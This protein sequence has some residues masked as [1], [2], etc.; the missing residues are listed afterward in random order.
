MFFKLERRNKKE[1]TPLRVSEVLDKHLDTLVRNIKIK[2]FVFMMMMFV[3]MGF[4]AYRFVIMTPEDLQKQ[5]GHIAHIEIS[6]EIS[7]SNRQGSGEPLAT[8][9][10]A[11]L[12][13]E[14]A[15]AILITANSGGGSPVQGEIINHAIKAVIQERDELG[16]DKPIVVV[17]EDVCASACY[18]AVSSAD[19]IYAHSSSLVGSIGVRMD[20]WQLADGLARLGVKR[21]TLTSGKNKALLDPFSELDETQSDKLKNDLIMP[22]FDMFVD[23]VKEARGNKLDLSE[24]DL[25]TGMVFHGQKA[26]AI[27]L[28]DDI[29]T[30]DQVLV[31]MRKK[32]DVQR[33]VT[34][35]KPKFSI[36]E[37]IMASMETAMESVLSETISIH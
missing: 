11:A 33:F 19:I 30:L 5:A 21:T 22:L 9:I 2:N 28:V 18:M 3:G 4:A 26:K 25:F 29:K 23:S 27:G 10:R 12:E 36:K 7:K 8:A 1:G 20:S 31:D 35:N 14:E 32:Y 13:K 6:G 37:M 24:P 17:M 15:K 16:I 34:Y